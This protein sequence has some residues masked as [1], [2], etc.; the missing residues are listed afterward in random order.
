MATR[1]TPFGS[2]P[3]LAAGLAGGLVLVL[4]GGGV[5]LAMSG[6]S[7]PQYRLA[8]ASM[9][10]VDQTLASVGT[11]AAVNRAVLAFPVAGTVASVPATVG[12]R[13]S[14]GQL[15][16]SLSTTDLQQQV[17][18]ATAVLAADQQS[19]ASDEA[20]QTSAASAS[21]STSSTTSQP[22]SAVRTTTSAPAS[23]PPVNGS[24]STGRGGAT[25]GSA[26]SRGGGSTAISQAQQQ[27]V[28]A[29]Q[30][31]DADL[32]AAEDAL[33]LCQA[34]LSQL[35]PT[36]SSANPSSSPTASSSDTATATASATGSTA[37]QLARTGFPT[38]SAS[39]SGSPGPG[40]GGGAG[41]GS[42]VA[43]CLDAIAKAPN[44][45]RTT[46][47]EDA[48]NRA[49]ASLDKAV[50]A[51]LAASKAT[52]SGSGAAGSGT[53]SGSSKAGSGTSGT[54]TSTGTGSTSRT[55][56]GL[57]GS[58]SAGARGSSGPASAQQLAAD[59]SQIDAAQAELAVAQQNVAEAQL[60][61]PLAGTVAAISLVA[62]H[63]V[64]AGS[65]SA[66]ITVIGS[67]QESVTTTVALADVDSIK[68]GDRA[69]VRVD[70]I[71]S[72]LTGTVSAVGILNTTT[73]TTT[74][75][76]VTIMLAPSAAHLYDGSGASV[77]I[78]VSSVNNVLTVPS[79]AVRTIGQLSTVTV[80]SKGKPVLTRVTI[81]AVGTDRTQIKSGLSAGAQVVLANLSTPLPTSS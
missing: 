17:T 44:K 38:G 13:V 10:S 39:P 18:S 52:G 23:A 11:V 71:S 24:G 27:L 34:D 3:R 76:P 42:G 80:L 1:V 4:G 7:G 6:S 66:T 31:L 78:S 35:P 32:S 74:S 67:G 22:S 53:T 68:V 50:Q 72:A 19:L 46:T 77:Q 15:L 8:T 48:R 49:E 40:G 64:S 65:S 70:G 9:A 28:R 59:Q 60:T 79:S 41:G 25:G 81:G 33:A 20:S 37:G 56:S 12:E 2:R 5:A 30:R 21:T 58:T 51:A 26:G 73:G 36:S 14:A 29:Q 47:D 55:G 43:G 16:A 61:S 62:G 45:A 63:S 69:S 57:S 75:Y 54:G